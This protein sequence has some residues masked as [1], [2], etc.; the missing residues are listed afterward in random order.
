M[1]IAGRRDSSPKHVLIFIHALDEGGEEE[2]ELRVLPGSGAGLEE[3]ASGVGPKGPV[4]VFARSVHAGKGLF[5][6]KADQPMPVGDLLHDLHCDLVLVAGGVG[7]AVDRGHFVLGRGHLVVFGLG[8]DAELPQF[9]V[10]ILHI[11]GNSGSDRAKIV[12]LQFLSSGG[13]GAKQRSAG[14]DQVFT[15]IVELLVKKKVLLLSADLR[16]HTV[17][18]FIAEKTKDAHSLLAHCVHRTK[19]RGLLIQRVSGIGAEDRGNAQ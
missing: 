6:Q 14:H 19:E 13:L 11:S 7:V 16:D 1:V 18:L 8:E 4:V 5:M 9:I 17:C 2:K 10:Q 3:I 12:I 15:L